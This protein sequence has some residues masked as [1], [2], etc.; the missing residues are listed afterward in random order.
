[1]NAS[2]SL[3]K[4]LTLWLAMD[5][6]LLACK[7]VFTSKVLHISSDSCCLFFFVPA[8]FTVSSKSH[9][10]FT[11]YAENL[12]RVTVTTAFTTVL[13]RRRNRMQTNSENLQTLGSGRFSNG[14]VTIENRN[15]YSRSSNEIFYSGER[16]K[17][18]A[19][20][21]WWV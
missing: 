21:V 14:T 5:P 3:S 11:S 12:A 2:F 13:Y 18:C 6:K 4:D 8:N 16:P 10:A 19:W 1:M 20:I 17:I 15:A 7:G 9:V